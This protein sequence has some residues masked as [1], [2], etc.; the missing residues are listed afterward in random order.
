MWCSSLNG[1]SKTWPLV[2]LSRSVASRHLGHVTVPFHVV[3][4][5]E[6]SLSSLTFVQLD[7]S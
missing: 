3:G 2:A 4:R 6:K 1:G 5:S 7:F